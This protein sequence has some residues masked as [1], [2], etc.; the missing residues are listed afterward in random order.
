M[1]VCQ[2]SWAYSSQNGKGVQQ[3]ILELLAADLHHE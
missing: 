1:A 3:A 2:I